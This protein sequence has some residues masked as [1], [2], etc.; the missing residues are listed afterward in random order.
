MKILAAL[1][2]TL[3]GEAVLRKA[4]KTALQQ[5]AKLEIMVVA[6]NFSDVGDVLDPGDV[7]EKLLN[8]ARQAAEKYR[9]LAQT[10]GVSAKIIVESGVSP[11]DIIVKRAEKENLDLIVLGRRAKKGLDR[12]LIGSVANKVV[13]YAPCSV[14]VVR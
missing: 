8:S 1:D 13:A 12:F 2:Q 10:L 9:K 11:A 14:L 4:V 3:S 5:N 7:N 6:E